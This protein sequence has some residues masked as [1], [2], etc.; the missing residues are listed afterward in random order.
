[1]RIARFTAPPTREG[2][3]RASPYSST[4]RTISSTLGA[5]VVAH[6]VK[7]SVSVATIQDIATGFFTIHLI[8]MFEIVDRESLLHC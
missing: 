5:G 4:R 2:Q 3:S 8:E 1:M 7:P 6:A